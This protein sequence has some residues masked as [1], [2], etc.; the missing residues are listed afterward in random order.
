VQNSKGNL[1][2]SQ[3]S[4]PKAL[5]NWIITTLVIMSKTHAEVEADLVLS[6]K[7]MAEWKSATAKMEEAEAEKVKLD[8][9][10]IE[11]D[12]L[13]SDNSKRAYVGMLSEEN[14]FKANYVHLSKFFVKS[15]II[16][17]V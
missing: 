16:S 9:S 12:F 2:N 4:L 13:S 14:R 10:G 17:E 7:K 1:R 15:G 3:S 11:G 8:I 6:N 5:K